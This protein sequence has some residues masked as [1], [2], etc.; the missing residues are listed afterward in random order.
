MTTLD[1]DKPPLSELAHYGIKGMKWGVRRGG[2]LTRFKGAIDDNS[3]RQERILVR[4]N[5]GRS[6]GLEE[7]IASGMDIILSGGKRR[8]VARNK[9]TIN[10]LRQKQA[11]IAK[12]EMAVR[13]MLSGLTTVSMLDLVVSR[14]D[15][16]G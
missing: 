2:L 6:K 10:K 5:E 7:K 15:N 16:R 11:R 4:R 9:E 3:Q 14:R 12:G 1:L 13:D 8:M